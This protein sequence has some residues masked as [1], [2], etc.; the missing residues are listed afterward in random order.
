ML[1]DAGKMDISKSPNN[2][3]RIVT[4]TGQVEKTFSLKQK[5]LKNYQYNNPAIFRIF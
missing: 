3:A 4:F 5:T 2:I 1:I